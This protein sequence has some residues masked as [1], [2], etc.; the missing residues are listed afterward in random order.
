MSAD[1][2]NISG[3]RRDRDFA[4]IFLI[5]GI[6][7]LIASLG[8]LAYGVHSEEPRYFLGWLISTSFWLSLGLGFLFMIM[9]SYLFDAGWLVV[10]RRPL[11]HAVGG[12]KYMALIFLPLLLLGIAF[13]END[14]VAWSWI[15]EARI[16]ATGDPVGEDPLYLHKAGYLDSAFFALRFIFY[17]GVWVLFA[18]L[19]RQC[20]FRMD[21]EGDPKYVHRARKLSAGGT[22]V[23]AIAVTFAAIDWFMS[24]EFHWFST[25]YGV[26]FF[27]SSMRGAICAMIILGFLA[28]TYGPL[29]G[30]YRGG[31]TY[32]LGCLLLAFTV[33][34]AYISF[35]QYF[36]IYSANIPEEVFWYNIREIHADG[37][38]NSWW[39]V[40]MGLIFGGF[41]IP[42]ILL[43]WNR[44]KFG[45]AVVGVAIWA[46]L[47]HLLDLYW[48]I[49]PG[50]VWDAA[51]GSYIV[52]Q[53]DIHWMD[54]TT[55]VGI[56]A[57]C[58][59]AYLV[60]AR[61]ER[62]IPIRDPRIVESINCHE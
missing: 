49:L 31:H 61:R 58:V 38:K 51:T 7:A 27:S 54:V 33:F 5:V 44:T 56:G 47:F 16:T 8:G 28:A 11:E 45:A 22:I 4:L 20:S 36:L 46:L 17:F 24:L 10:L 12:F 9:L 40:S 14:F 52:R 32:L 2:A 48:N 50:K 37:T 39:W 1:P 55:F 41:L 43:L 26:W 30:I 34:W 59:W 21:R 15:D 29:K 3:P 13:A 6:V 62:A 42:F 25:M 19:L 18:E 35:S 53:F 57:I 23:C 60:S